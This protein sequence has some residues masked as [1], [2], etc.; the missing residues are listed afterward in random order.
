MSVGRMTSLMFKSP[1]GKDAKRALIDC[2]FLLGAKAWA[3]VSNGRVCCG[4]YFW[5]VLLLSRYDWVPVSWFCCAGRKGERLAAIPGSGS[6]MSWGR[7][8]WDS[9]TEPLW[10]EEKWDVFALSFFFFFFLLKFFF[11]ILWYWVDSF[12]QPVRGNRGFFMLWG[13]LDEKCLLLVKCSR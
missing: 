1:N 5:A 9:T 12:L 13:F 8:M 6:F 7:G 2:G 10:P 4:S 3:F 11:P